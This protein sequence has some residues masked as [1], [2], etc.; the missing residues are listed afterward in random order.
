[1]LLLG[2]NILGSADAPRLD[3]LPSVTATQEAAYH[4]VM[5]IA[6]TVDFPLVQK[7]GDIYFIH[8][9]SELHGRDHSAGI[10]DGLEKAHHSLRLHLRDDRNE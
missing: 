5:A 8:G 3:S 7:P 2:K 9:L 10:T 4:A 1:M 6:N